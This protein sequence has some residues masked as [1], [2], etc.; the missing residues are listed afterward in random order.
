MNFDLQW[1]QNHIGTLTTEV[2]ALR[3]QVVSLTD[4]LEDSKMENASLKDSLDEVTKKV[5][6]QLVA[7]D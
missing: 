6:P 5:G 2:A 3:F 4:Q 1:L 7:G